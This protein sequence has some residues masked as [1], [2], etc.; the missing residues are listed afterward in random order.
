MG[1]LVYFLLYELGPW[2]RG[3]WNYL[4]DVLKAFV[5]WVWGF[6]VDLLRPAWQPVVEA[7]DSL[8]AA[9]EIP[10]TLAMRNIWATGNVFLPLNEAATLFGLLLT[11]QCVMIVIRTIKKFIPT[12]S[13]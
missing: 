5:M 8:A 2:L 11:L 1:Q 7:Y 9:M 13:G 3:F 4:F 6:F 10:N 12:M